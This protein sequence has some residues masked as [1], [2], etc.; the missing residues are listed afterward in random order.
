MRYKCDICGNEIELNK[1][2]FVFR[3]N[4]LRNKDAYCCE[5]EM[6]CLTENKGMPTIIRNE[7]TQEDR[8][9]QHKAKQRERRLKKDGYDKHN[10]N[11]KPP[12]RRI[13]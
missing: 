2:T 9:I 12:K 6:V 10:P 8:I 13:K 11:D 7:Y 1:Y 5:Q 4:K 3:N